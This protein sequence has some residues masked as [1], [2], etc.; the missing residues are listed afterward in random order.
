M[1]DSNQSSGDNFQSINPNAAEMACRGLSHERARMALERKYEDN[2]Y[3]DH[4]SKS[5]IYNEM[6]K[7][8]PKMI[9]FLNGLSGKMEQRERA[10]NIELGLPRIVGIRDAYNADGSVKMG[11]CVI[12]YVYGRRNSDLVFDKIRY[13]ELVVSDDERKVWNA[14]RSDPIS[15]LEKRKA[16]ESSEWNFGKDEKAIHK[17]A[18]LQIEENMGI[19]PKA[20][21]KKIAK[22]NDVADYSRIKFTGFSPYED[23]RYQSKR[24]F[25]C[26]GGEFGELVEFEKT[27]C[28]IGTVSYAFKREDGTT[29][30]GKFTIDEFCF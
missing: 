3:D 20:V 28:P 13:S 2:N 9:S 21:L 19:S 17:M 25:I 14:S 30:K 29:K 23:K 26:G 22:F 7:Y 4:I 27:P 8:M 15:G 1:T 10:R 18:Q 11:D 16:L 24:P 5:S 12:E 6:L